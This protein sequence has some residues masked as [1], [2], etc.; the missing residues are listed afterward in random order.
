MS[1]NPLLEDRDEEYLQQ[2][3]ELLE[4]A[5]EIERQRSEDHNA[6]LKAAAEGE[7]LVTQEY[8][9]TEIGSATLTVKTEIE[10]SVMRKLDTVFDG[11]QPPGVMLDTYVDVLTSQTVEIEA[12]DISVSEEPDIRLFWRDFLDTNDVEKA[13]M[14]A[15]D[16][17]IQDPLELEQE[18]RSEAVRGFRPNR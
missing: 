2:R 11:D 7:E 13:A 1:T 5:P 16:R 3:E 10:G 4:A 15:V 6:L 18:R 12:G 9:T 17:V 8:E 14:L